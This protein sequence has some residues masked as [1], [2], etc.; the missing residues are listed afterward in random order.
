MVQRGI[1]IARGPKEAGY[2]F[3]SDFP[4]AIAL[5]SDEVKNKVAICRKLKKAVYMDI[6]E[7]EEL[8]RHIRTMLFAII[9]SGLEAGVLSA[10]GCGE[11][12]HP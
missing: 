3:L 11:G 10:I 5:I 2:P 8:Q 9:R 1:K 6:I 12:G 4:E 7:K